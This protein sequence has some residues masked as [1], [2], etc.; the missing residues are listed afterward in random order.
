MSSVCLVVL[1]AAASAC[2]DLGA[3]EAACVPPGRDVGSSISNA[4]ILSAQAV[5]TA[6]YTP[7]LEK[8]HVGWD[9]VQWSAEDGIAGIR[10]LAYGEWGDEGPFLAAWVTE[11]CDVSAAT[12][13]ESGYPDIERYEAIESQTAEI[14]ITIIPTGELPLVRAQLYVDELAGVEVDDRPVRL[15][16]DDAIEDRVGPRVNVALLR[17]QFVWIVDELDAEEGTVELRSN[18]PRA[19]GSGLEPDEAL[20]LI[21]EV[22]PEA[23]YRG[24]WYFTFDGGCITYEFNAKGSLAATVAEDAEDALGFFP[25]WRLDDIPRD[26]G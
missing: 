3:G 4:N 13:V 5:P 18:D 9:A 8:L 22:I 6:Q 11:S 25:A 20:D 15:A 7:C 12:P 16:I 26:A 14:P 24:D 21:E 1:A 17:D 23:F 2:S 10:I 19:A